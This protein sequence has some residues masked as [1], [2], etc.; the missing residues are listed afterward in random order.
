M[1]G[2]KSVLAAGD[3][4]TECVARLQ[5]DG[6]RV[7][8]RPEWG[9][10]ELAA[11]VDDYE[12]LVAGPGAPV[13][14]AVLAAGRALEVVGAVGADVAGIDVAEATRRGILVVHAPDSALISE[15]EHALALVL[16]VARDL[17]GA[18]AALRGGQAGHVP[19]AGV[20]VR[21]KTLGLVGVRASSA[22][23]R[24]A[25]PRAGHDRAG[26]RGAGPGRGDR[27][28]GRLRHAGAGARPGRRARR[29][30]AA[31]VCRCSARP[32]WR[33]SSRARGWS[34]RARPTPW[35]P[36]RSPR[37]SSADVWPAPPSPWS[38]AW[39]SRRRCS[40]RPDCS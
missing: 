3:L 2:V 33:S 19:G 1:N 27:R 9:E 24:R 18:D 13:T 11:G 8:V 30:D 20:E 29:A 40:P 16:A 26:L 32:S 6:L 39:R 7:D 5:E 10:P 28:R 14:A 23:A 35:T 4:A 12:A 38:P 36:R 22:L 15:A 31:R 34:A 37:P 17:A 21:G 25:R